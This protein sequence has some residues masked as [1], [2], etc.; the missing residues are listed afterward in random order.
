MGHVGPLIDL[1]VPK[2]SKPSVGQRHAKPVFFFVLIIHGTKDFRTDPILEP[3]VHGHSVVLSHFLYAE[4]TLDPALIQSS[5]GGTILGNIGI[6]LNHSNLF[7]IFGKGIIQPIFSGFAAFRKK[8][9]DREHNCK[10]KS[11]VWKRPFPGDAGAAWN[12]W[13][14]C[15]FFHS[16]VFFGWLDEICWDHSIFYDSSTEESNTF[17]ARIGFPMKQTPNYKDPIDTGREAFEDSYLAPYA[18]HHSASGGRLVPEE[19]DPYRPAFQRDRDRI[20]HSRAFRRL[21][22]K[23]QVFINSEGDNYRTRLTHSLEVS[24]ISRSVAAALGLNRDFAET[25]ALAHDLGHTPFG[26]AG[27]EALH[28]VM[29][30]HGGFEHNCQSLRTVMLLEVRYLDF[31]G[32]NLTRGTL[33]G[34][35]KHGCT[36][37]CRIHTGLEPL[38]TERASE[39]PSLEASIVD[40]CDRIAY[41][42]HDLEDGLDSGYLVLEELNG[43]EAWDRASQVLEQTYGNHF[44]EKRKEVRIR[45]M[46]RHL[47]NEAVRDLIQTTKAS[48]E[49]KMFQAF[50]DVLDCPGAEYPV[51]NSSEQSDLLKELQSHLYQNLYRHPAVMKMSRRGSRIIETLFE[52]Y[53]K[54]PEIMP[55]HIQLRIGEHG[56]HRVVADY[57][58]GMTDRFAVQEFSYITGTPAML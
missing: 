11:S 49:K 56:L 55:S 21:G 29:K 33:K 42:H 26:H 45:F 50:Q 18:I 52:E 27:E 40:A 41:I 13:F 34:M 14:F 10:E 12:H 2:H 6:E 35:M 16:G 46:I 1:I 9:D 4:N 5:N 3:D 25:V 8:E 20:V 19:E 43:L 53:V 17:A 22:Y 48:L 51:G 37:P 58:A 57:I 23:T 31:S 39:S 32:L 36:S 44:L 54:N 15:A 47:I 30:S 7:C 38:C 24:Q 28:T